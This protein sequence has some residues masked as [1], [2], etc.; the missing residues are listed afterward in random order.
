VVS[1]PLIRAIGI[2]EIHWQH[3]PHF[4]TLVYQIDATRK[5]LVVDRPVPRAKTLL[6]FFRWF[7]AERMAALACIC[8]DRWKPYLQV[9]TKNAARAPHLGPLSYRQAHERC[10]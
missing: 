2:D 1:R 3:G 5:T 4:L 7:G 6:R 9:V 10:D 8:S